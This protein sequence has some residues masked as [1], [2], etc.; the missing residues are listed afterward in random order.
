MLLTEFAF[1]ENPDQT[2]R[3][4]V[5]AVTNPLRGGEK[6][7]RP[8]TT[9]NGIGNKAYEIRSK[10][11]HGK[12]LTTDFTDNTDTETQFIR[13]HPA[14]SVVKTPWSCHFADIYTTVKENLPINIEELKAA[15][16]DPEVSLMLN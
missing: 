15:A 14:L 3:A 12:E 4:I 11:H 8:T 9:P 2:W 13:F 10:N 7:V 5:P 6:K 1:V 16:D